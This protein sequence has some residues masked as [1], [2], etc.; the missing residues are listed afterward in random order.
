MAVGKFFEELATFVWNFVAERWLVILLYSIIV[1][2]SYIVIKKVITPYFHPLHKKLSGS[3]GVLREMKAVLEGG[4]EE[5]HWNNPRFCKTYLALYSSYRELRTVVIRD[6]RG[7]IDPRNH[8]WDEFD[9][10]AVGQKARPSNEPE[11]PSSAK[12]S[13]SSSAEA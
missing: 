11:E 10:V 1:I 9:N 4:Y 8:T 13:E 2:V 3:R 7:S 12:E 5:Y 6:H